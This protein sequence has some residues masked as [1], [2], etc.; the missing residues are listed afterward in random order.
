MPAKTVH[1][2][3]HGSIKLDGLFLELADRHEMQRLRYVRQL[4]FG[5]YVFPGANHTRFEHSLGVYH[6]SGKMADALSLSK[7][8]SDTVRAAGMLHDICHAPFSHTLDDVI[9]S[10]LGTDH[11]ELARMLIEGR[12]KTYQDK[13]EEILAGTGPISEILEK[14]GISAEKVCDLIAFPE[15]PRPDLNSF[16]RDSGQSFFT[17]GDYL[18]QIIHG[19]VD[20]DQMDYLLRDAHYT[21]VTHGLIDVERLLSTI[22]VFNDRLVVEK[23]G[24]TAA[25]GL[26]VSRSL[27]YTSVYYHET[28]RVAEM[29]MLKALEASNLDIG[30]IHLWTDYELTLMMENQGKRSARIVRSIMNRRLYKKAFT[31]YTADMSE[32]EIHN[33]AQYTSYESRK[34]L[35]QEIADIADVDISEVAVDIPSESALFSKISI[36]KTDVS[37]LDGERV[38]SITKLSSISKSL[39]ARDVFRWAVLVSCP[40]DK[41]EAV[42]KAAE[43]VLSL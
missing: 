16:S 38:R 34:K 4:G 39:Q 17:S 11:M 13:D 9:E 23:G 14:N 29:M 27:M 12:I 41:F 24:M 22:R 26:M 32:D 20:S 30:D 7:E 33:L 28:V 42:A 25:E 37:I 8:E 36:G 6:L 10:R 19:P 15:A 43:S 31:G 21:G 5:N 18:H 2:P 40:A 35:E 3:L 1:D